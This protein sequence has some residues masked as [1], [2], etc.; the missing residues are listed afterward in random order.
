MGGIIYLGSVKHW[1]ERVRKSLAAT[2]G[3]LMT[4]DPVTVGPTRRR[5]R[6]GA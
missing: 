4:R 1:E 5:T 2:V 3:D 6:P